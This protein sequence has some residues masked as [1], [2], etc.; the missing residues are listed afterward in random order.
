MQE[1]VEPLIVPNCPPLLSVG[2]RCTEKGWDFWWPGYGTPIF[3]KPDGTIIEHVV[4]N[5]CPYVI[6]KSMI[7]YQDGFPEAFPSVVAPLKNRVWDHEPN[8][9]ELQTAVQPDSNK[10]EASERK[11][12][13]QEIALTKNGRL[14]EDAVSISHML[15]HV[16]KN[17]FCITCQRSKMQAKPAPNRKGKRRL[18]RDHT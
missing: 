13:I 5:N 16:P 9:E 12:E 7:D 6:D 14:K 4:K 2:Y 15:T 18:P 8:S 10:G 17:P 3:T 11:E 1:D